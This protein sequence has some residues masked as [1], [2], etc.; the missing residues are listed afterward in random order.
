MGPDA[1]LHEV[2]RL[3]SSIEYRAKTLVNL[4]QEGF[5]SSLL[6]EGAD[7]NHYPKENVNNVASNY[8]FGMMLNGKKS[9]REVAKLTTEKF[10]D[11]S[12]SKS[13]LSSRTAAIK[14]KKCFNGRLR[15][16]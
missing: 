4:I 16:K 14:D 5:T 2:K 15:Q 11:F 8:A 10:A 13:T 1:Q 9:S 12:I 3:K 6:E 7:D